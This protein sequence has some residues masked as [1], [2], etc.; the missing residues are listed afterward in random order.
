MVSVLDDLKPEISIQNFPASPFI[1]DEANE[2]PGEANNMM[3]LRKHKYF[4]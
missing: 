3:L 2:Y 1:S 4:N